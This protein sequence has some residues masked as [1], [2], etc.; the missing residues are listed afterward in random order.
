M[1]LPFLV[2]IGLI[3]GIMQT[4]EDSIIE[5]RVYNKLLEIQTKS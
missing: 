3:A 4:V 1:I 5:N 2:V